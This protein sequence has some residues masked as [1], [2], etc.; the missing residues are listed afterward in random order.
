M[1]RQ[2]G[3]GQDYIAGPP[4]LRR[5]GTGRPRWRLLAVTGLAVVVVGFLAGLTGTTGG[6][7]ALGLAVVL[8]GLLGAHHAGGG[9]RWLARAAAEY[10]VV[11]VLVALLAAHYGPHAPPAAK[12]PARPKPAAAAPARPHPAPCP[13]PS[14]ARA[15]LACIWHR[16]MDPAPTPSPTTTRRNR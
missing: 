5:R 3:W 10:A 9:V 7:V 4:L 11:A 2:L 13:T 12:D 8:V 15:W 1:L 16:A 14:Q 6:L